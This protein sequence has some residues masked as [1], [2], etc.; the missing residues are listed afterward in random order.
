MSNESLQKVYDA[1][2]RFIE[3]TSHLGELRRALEAHDNGAEEQSAPETPAED[4]PN[5]ESLPMPSE[6]TEAPAHGGESPEP[7]PAL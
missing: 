7:E 4:D 1:A 3:D 5:A 2:Q 6:T